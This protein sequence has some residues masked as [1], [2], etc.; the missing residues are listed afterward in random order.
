MKT[1]QTEV[2]DHLHTPIVFIH[3]GDLF[4]HNMKGV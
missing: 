1:Q 3:T 2:T 4:Q